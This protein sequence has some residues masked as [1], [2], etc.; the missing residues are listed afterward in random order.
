MNDSGSNEDG[1]ETGQLV[2]R[3]GCLD[4]ALACDVLDDLGHRNC[5]LGPSV[6]AVYPA[7]PVVGVAFTMAAS[8]VTDVH[9]PDQPYEM[10]LASYE[11]MR[12]NEVI[13]IATDGDRRSSIWGEL[14]SIAAAAR[15]ITGLV[16][17]GS[18][19]DLHEMERLGFPVFAS[20]I[21]PLDAAGRLEV[22]DH[23]LPIQC[24]GVTVRPGDFVLGDGMGVVAVPREAIGDVLRLAEEKQRS[25]SEVRQLLAHGE[26]IS[27]VFDRY[28][29]L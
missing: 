19:R 9:V 18:V 20:G 27:D 11:H 21:S 5:F 13:V 2:R 29:I 23:S 4:T 1:R 3:L 10:L 12:P 15:G 28:K 17:D 26:N 14:L 25:E 16:T 6:G 24:G 8:T 7:G 22:R